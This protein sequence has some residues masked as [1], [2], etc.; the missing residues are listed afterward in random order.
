MDTM[1]SDIEAAVAHLESGSNEPIAASESENTQK[2]TQKDPV[3][4]TF[5]KE[6]SENDNKTL[7]T[8]QNESIA[9]ENDNKTLKTE[10]NESISSESTS[11]TPAAKADEDP[12]GAT[13]ALKAPAGWTPKLRESWS[14]VPAEVQAQ[15]NAREKEMSASMANTSAARTTHD[16][17]A[18]LGQSFAPIMAAEGISDPVEAAEGLFNTVSKLRMGSPAQ[19]AQVISELISSYGVDISTLDDLIVGN[20]PQSSPNADMERLID[21]R[22]EPLNQVM[23][24][25]NQQQQQ[26]GAESK[27]QAEQ[28]IKSFAEN[29]EFLGDVR[30]DM[31]NIIDYAG[32]QGRKMGM[33]EA[34]D[35]AVAMN[36]EIQQVIAQRKITGGNTAITAKHTAASSIS[37]RKAGTGNVGNGAMS[38]RE[39]ISSAWD[40]A[41]HS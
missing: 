25:L 10:Q 16:R 26:K 13:Q 15:I 1:S 17:M 41:A 2:T 11:A 29:A 18:K 28:E 35:T 21:Q 14:K 19:K 40:D 12:S 24:M 32:S 36:P 7:K 39:S 33:K 5:S 8:E 34:Y 6:S 37:G 22:M 23:Q 30:M 27:V 20:T 4:P 9:S 3:D 38:I 31:A